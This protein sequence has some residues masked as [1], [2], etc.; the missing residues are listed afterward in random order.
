MIQ[1][2]SGIVRYSE[3]DENGRLSLPSLINLFQDV[4]TLHGDSLGIGVHYL[5]DHHLAW[6]VAFWQIRMKRMPEV[7][8]PYRLQT[9]G[10]KFFGIFGMRNCTLLDG[11]GNMLASAN[12]V[13]FLYDTEKEVPVRVPEEIQEKY[14]VHPRLEMDYAPRKVKDPEDGETFEPFKVGRQNLDTNH[15]VNNAQ[16]VAMAQAF[17]PEG[18]H[19]SELRI[20]Y[21][22]QA[23][24]YDVITPLVQKR[25][26]GFGVS[27]RGEDG[28]PYISAVFMKESH[29][30]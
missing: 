14:G 12:S 3:C 19:F 7:D 18:E 20:E 2:L 16:Y 6:L 24:L 28:E 23:H 13:W 8:E 4:A 10:W 30:L 29:G 21:K 26:D 25:E 27:L 22:K 11:E 17:L 1:E 9:W 15:H 5:K